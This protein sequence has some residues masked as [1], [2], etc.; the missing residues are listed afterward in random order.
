MAV[1]EIS[2]KVRVRT[3]RRDLVSSCATL[4]WEQLHSRPGLGLKKIRGLVE[5]LAIAA[6]G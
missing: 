6:Q 2:G 3:R 1:G 4:R 5:M